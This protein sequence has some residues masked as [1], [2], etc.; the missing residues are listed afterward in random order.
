MRRPV[1]LFTLSAA[2][3]S[4]P[5]AAAPAF[6]QSAPVVVGR[7]PVS[8]NVTL[9][10]SVEEW[11]KTETA[12]VTLVVDAASN[13]AENSGTLR[14]DILKAVAGVADK[15]EW[16]ITRM[17]QQSDSAGLERWQAELEA[18][19]PESQLAALADRTKKASRP[20]LQVRVGEV[21]FEPTLA[22]TEAARAKLRE[23][24]YAKVNDEVKRLKA[25][26]PGRDY[27]VGQINF[28]ER[29]DVMVTGS[30][31]KRE[32]MVAAAPMAA[33]VMAGVQDKMVVTAN[34]TL[35]SFATPPAP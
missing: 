29:T 27:R 23:Q 28:A 30:R 34:I 4:L 18:R 19:L 31:A 9:N 24:I 15:A 21:A 5:L 16:R 22:E 6:A 14:A 25:A 10:L 12:R 32:M 1:A 3:L 7:A 13:G 17:D 35:S 33:D 8:D 26:F 2:L 11:V 20:G